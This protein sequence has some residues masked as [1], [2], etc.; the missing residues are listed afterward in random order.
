VGWQDLAVAVAVALA[1]YTLWRRVRPARRKTVAVIPLSSI[2][3]RSRQ[4][5]PRVM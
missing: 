3:V 4:P 1:L 5:P 2:K